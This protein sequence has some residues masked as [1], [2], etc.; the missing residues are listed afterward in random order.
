ML[1]IPVMMIGTSIWAMT[2]IS[3]ETKSHREIIEKIPSVDAL[4]TQIE[5]S[6]SASELE[7]AKSFAREL[8]LLAEKNHN[9]FIESVE[10]L[11]AFFAL[12]VSAA[13]L[14]LLITVPVGLRLWRS[15]SR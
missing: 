9:N 13:V 4:L 6:Q 12:Q 11:D 7:E 1:A 3:Q 8:S 14:W 10:A 15:D 5:K 2:F